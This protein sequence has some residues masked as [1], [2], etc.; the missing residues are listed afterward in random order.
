[1]SR[2]L[3]GE[4]NY[5]NMI[6]SATQIAARISTLHNGLRPLTTEIIA[7]SYGLEVSEIEPVLIHAQRKGLLRHHHMYGWITLQR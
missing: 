1:V 3:T 4:Y 7:Q 2:Y 5:G 6:P